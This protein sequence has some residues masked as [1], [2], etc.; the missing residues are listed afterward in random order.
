MPAVLKF[1]TGNKKKLEEF[2]KIVGA[3]RKIENVELDLPELQGEPDDI[4][5]QKCLL[6]AE[7]VKGPVVVEDT[8]LEFNALHGLPGPYIKWFL[9]KMKVDGLPN[10]LAAYDDKSAKAVCTIAF[11]DGQGSKPRVF[12]GETLGKIVEPRG[13][14]NFGWDPVFEP[15]DGNGKTYAQMDPERKNEISHRKKA[16]ELLKKFLDQHYG[17]E[18]DENENEKEKASEDA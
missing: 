12:R 7:K 3:A 18:L 5:K 15:E 2:R 11:C 16:L 13:P 10:L 17:V 9:D 6:A 14:H 4:A 1:V 8:C